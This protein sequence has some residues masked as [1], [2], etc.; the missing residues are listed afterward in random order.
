MTYNLLFNSEFRDDKNWEFI[1][2]EYIDNRLKSTNKVFGLKQK[3]ILSDITRLYARCKYNIL[4]SQVYSVYI[5]IEVDGKLYVNKQWTR[6]DKEKIISLVEDSHSEVITLHIIFESKEINNEIILK[7]PLLYDLSRWHKTF[8]LKFILD[9]VIKY[10]P[11]YNYQ[12]ILEYSEITPEIFNLEKAK[13]GSIIST[14]EKTP[15]KI[16]AKLLRGHT[17]LVKLDYVE[18]NTLG[19]FYINYGVLKSRKYGKEQCYISF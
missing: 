15:L 5:G 17:Y 11:G 9:R 19:K 10:R 7:E 18:I 4:N 12:N 13:I 8:A 14:N 3:I 16:N 6:V 2:C 1:N